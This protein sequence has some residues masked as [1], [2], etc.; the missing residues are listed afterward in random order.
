MR[1]QE[2]KTAI[3]GT[4]HLPL[5]KGEKRGG[6]KSSVNGW[7]SRVTHHLQTKEKGGNGGRAV[8]PHA[9]GPIMYTP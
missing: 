4:G 1:I 7:M 2:L 6:G 5:T 9:W 3:T 8:A